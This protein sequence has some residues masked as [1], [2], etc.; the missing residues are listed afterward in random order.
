MIAAHG[1]VLHLEPASGE[2][3]Q[4]LAEMAGLLRAELLELDVAAVEPFADQASPEDTKGVAT[5]IG[6]L[7]VRFGSDGLRAVT[8]A[9]CNW[10]VRNNRVVEVTYGDDTLKV[11]GAT[12]E[13]QERIIDAWLARHA[14]GS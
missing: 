3:G 9:V 7:A 10:A 14:S 13:Q 8:R 1:L 2:D 5:I 11:T 12:S 4:E 6:W